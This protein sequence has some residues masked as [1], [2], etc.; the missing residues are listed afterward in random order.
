MTIQSDTELEKTLG[1]FSDYILLERG[2]SDNTRKAYD[3]D[4]AIWA[5]YCKAAGADPLNAGA[6]AVSRFL[7]AQQ[8]EG[9]KKSTVQR[10][11]A[12][13]RSFAKFLQ[14]DGDTDKCGWPL[15]RQENKN[16]PK[17]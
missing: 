12:V 6:D 13:M 4:I 17:S 5:A 15:F 1:R 11:G 10:L 16:C 14:F 8:S 3:S 9:K 7:L 2:C